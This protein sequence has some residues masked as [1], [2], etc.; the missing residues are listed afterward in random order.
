MIVAWILGVGL[1]L[2]SR[3]V[4]SNYHITLLQIG[5]LAVAIAIEFL[6]RYVVNRRVENLW[7][8]E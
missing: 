3:H 4:S 5:C 6:T 7:F 2:I 1:Y 8:V